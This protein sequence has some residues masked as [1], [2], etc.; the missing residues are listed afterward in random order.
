MNVF[1][2]TQAPQADGTTMVVVKDNSDG[3]VNNFVVGAGQT[4]YFSD[5][6]PADDVGNESDATLIDDHFVLVDSNGTI[7]RCSTRPESGGRGSLAFWMQPQKMPPVHHE[8]CDREKKP[9]NAY[10]P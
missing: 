8:E 10:Y 9:E 4:L 7:V 1:T 5:G 2:V 6:N 3:T